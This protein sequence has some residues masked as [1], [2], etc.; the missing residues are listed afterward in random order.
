MTAAVSAPTAAQLAVGA[1]GGLLLVLVLVDLFVTIFGYD[2]F[3]FLAPRAHRALWALMRWATSWLPKR[4]RRTLLAL[5]SAGLLPATIA[6]WLGLEMAAFAMIYVPGLASGGFVVAPHAGRGAGSAFYLS[7]G[8]LTSLT[9]G[10]Y[11]PRAPLDRA[12]LDFE[13]VVGIATFTLAI[14][15]VLSAFDALAKLRSVHARVRR[16]AVEPHRPSTILERRYRSG[17][18]S[19]YSDFL[20]AIVEGLDEYDEGLRRFPVA[21]YFHTRR[22]ERSMP[23]IMA[24]LGQLI[25]LSRWGLPSSEAITRDPNLLALVEGYSTRMAPWYLERVRRVVSAAEPVAIVERVTECRDPTDDKFLELA[26]NG[27][28]DLIVSGDRDLLT[29]H[30]LLNIPI[31]TPGYLCAG[32]NQGALRGPP[33]SHNL[34]TRGRAARTT[35]IPQWQRNMNSSR[36]D[37]MTGEHRRDAAALADQNAQPLSDADTDVIVTGDADLLVLHPFRGIILIV[38]PATFVGGAGRVVE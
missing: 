34:S 38:P 4:P 13:T 10:D 33:R 3:T 6:L 16:N 8:A 20:Q 17:D 24:A 25:E 19:Y 5:G 14:T 12:M 1:A 28:A 29:L 36:L 23:L 22:T 26:L 31:I 15:Y 30:P 21:F 37:A 7:G 32:V 35:E 2:G 9:F 18:A 11:I 27:R